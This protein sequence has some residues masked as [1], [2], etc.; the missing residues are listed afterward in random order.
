MP[1]TIIVPLD[2]SDFAERALRPARAFAE[3]AGANVIVMTAQPGD[4]TASEAML[5]GAAHRAG[6]DSAQPVVY[7][8]C[9]GATAIIASAD[10]EPDP[11]VC[12]TTHARGV[13][14]DA[15]LGS[16]AQEVLRRSDTPV[17]L[18]GPKVLV[19]ETAHYQELVV[20]LDG[21]RTAELVLPAATS[22]ARDLGLDVWLVG[23]INPLAGS[24]G[25]AMASAD[26]FEGSSLKRA[27]RGFADSGLTV[28]WETLHGTDPANA[29]IDFV[30]SRPQP[31]LAMTTHGHSALG[32]ITGGKPVSHLV[33]NVATH[34]RATIARIVAGSVTMS[35]VHKAPCPVLVTRS[36]ETTS[37]S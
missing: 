7:D 6:L 30:R 27:A 16:V 36:P 3:Q 8:D 33:Q 13:L 31:L 12:M 20:C 2:G 19:A 15:V 22:L 35:V 5:S 32:L 10:N 18:V 4:V 21:S 34:G 24:G 11:V 28:N 37:H 14:G 1:K 23:V 17:V 25:K 26:T 29:I 9:L